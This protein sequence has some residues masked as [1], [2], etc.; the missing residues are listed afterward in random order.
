[1]I[2]E[3]SIFHLFFDME[4]SACSIFEMKLSIVQYPVHQPLK[5]TIT[6]EKAIPMKRDSLMLLSNFHTC[7]VA[8]SF[9]FSPRPEMCS[10]RYRTC[11]YEKRYGEF[12]VFHFHFSVRRSWTDTPEK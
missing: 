7:F 5:P 6:A 11:T 3:F 8:A 2:P 1:M 12:F 9:I 10:Y 4:L